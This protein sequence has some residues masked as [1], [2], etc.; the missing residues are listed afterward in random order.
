MSTMHSRGL[1]DFR[2]VVKERRIDQHLYKD[3]GNGA[4]GY[5]LSVSW[6]GPFAVL[7]HFLD[8]L[9]DLRSGTG[10]VGSGEVFERTGRLDILECS[11][12]R[13]KFLVYLLCGL[14]SG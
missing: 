7:D 10:N 12:E 4:E 13:L 8:C 6:C 1:G 3:E 2:T 5:L 9:C 14:F 11:T